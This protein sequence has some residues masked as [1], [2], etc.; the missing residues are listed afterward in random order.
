MVI[1][2]LT[3][4]TI[5]AG[6]IGTLTGFG[7]STIMVP[8]LLLFF[9]LPQT[10]LLVGIIHWFGDIWKLILFRQ[11]IRWKI[12]LGFGIP[13]IITSFLGASLTFSAPEELMQR[14]LGGFLIAYV[15]FLFIKSSFKLPQNNYT[16]IS[17]GTLSG[18]F[19]GIFGIGGAVRSAFLSAFDLPKAVYLATT[20]G[21]ALII[22]SSRLV[23]YY[24]NGSRLESIL[25]WG[26]LAFVPASL[27]GAKLAKYIVE[28]IPQNYFRIVI[29]VFLFLTGLKLLLVP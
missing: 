12:L 29:A 17:G 11:G 15:I 19:A 27:L 10:L 23:T 24:M 5:F 25:M 16:A 22:D 1:V 28:K 3:I 4:L 14:I 13:G 26:L 20:G 6:G 2:Y 8:V 9:P 7:T 21:I 18:F